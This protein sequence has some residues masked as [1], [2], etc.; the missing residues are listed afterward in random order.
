[1]QAVVPS[2]FARNDQ[3]EVRA[4]CSGFQLNRGFFDLRLTDVLV[5]L[6]EASPAQKQTYSYADKTSRFE[7]NLASPSIQAA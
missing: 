6:L 4:L 3:R 2:G 5:R 1:L 7:M